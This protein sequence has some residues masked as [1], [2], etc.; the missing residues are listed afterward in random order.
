MGTI[1]QQKGKLEG[2]SV[3]LH[4]SSMFYTTAERGHEIADQ[5]ENKPLL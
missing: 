2:R 1:G 3:T 4:G 5:P